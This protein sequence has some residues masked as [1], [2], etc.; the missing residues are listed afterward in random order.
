M[1]SG[2]PCFPPRLTFA[3]LRSL[4]DLPSRISDLECPSFVKF[5][6][7]SLAFFV[8]V[9]NTIFTPPLCFPRKGVFSGRTHGDTDTCIQPGRRPAARRRKRA[10][11]ASAAWS[12]PA[13]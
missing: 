6:L 13:I 2:N 11:R 7:S 1:Q 10:D 9:Y 3:L 8:V 4:G 5:K 12:S